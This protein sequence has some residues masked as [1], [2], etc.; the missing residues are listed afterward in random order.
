M[1]SQ[2]F[3]QNAK[4]LS[5]FVYV[6]VSSELNDFA[7]F[8]KDESG[9]QVKLV[10]NPNWHPT[11]HVN[12]CAEVVAAPDRV[13]ARDSVRYEKPVGS[14][15]PQSY[16]GHEAISA[17]VAK[18]PPKA[19]VKTIP[20]YNCGSYTPEYQTLKDTVPL[21]K[22]GDKVYF[23]YNSLLQEDNF[24]YREENGDLVYRIHYMSVFCFVR[25][26]KITMLS[27]YVLLSSV[28]ELTEKIEVDGHQV[29]GKKHGNLVLIEK[30]EDV[31][32]NTKAKYLTGILEHIGMP[33]ADDEN[34]RII[35]PGT[36]VLFKPNS[37]FK[38]TIEGKEYLLMN[39]WDL[40][41]WLCPG[42]DHD[43]LMPVGDYVSISPDEQIIAKTKLI[44]FDATK[45]QEFKPGE[46]FI[47]D[48][49]TGHNRKIK[50]V[51]TGIVLWG[52]HEYMIKKVIYYKSNDYMYV[53][54]FDVVLVRHGDILG[55]F[56]EEV[57]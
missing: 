53:K 34:A 7:G 16:R 15:K 57:H 8:V 22:K 26:S 28:S 44:E 4:W 24:M 40:V 3:I 2:T 32:G 50:K 18:L 55:W 11:Q 19:K 23:H 38:N 14:P 35:V 27:G 10:L 54:E 48:G 21:I 6:R 46:L 5:D 49:A 20:R 12:I 41:A 39:Q 31:K 52:P 25:D 36:K 1:I 47:P 56:D 13:Y 9:N 45:P 51:G 37:Q 43:D 29:S 42:V 30:P 33:V 17:Y